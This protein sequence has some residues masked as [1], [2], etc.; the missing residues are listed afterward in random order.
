MIYS[1]G[2]SSEST[3]RHDG[4]IQPGPLGARIFTISA[5]SRGPPAGSINTATSPGSKVT[6][7]HSFLSLMSAMLKVR[8]DVTRSPRFMGP[9]RGACWM[10]SSFLKNRSRSI[11]TTRRLCQQNNRERRVLSS[12]HLIPRGEDLQVTRRLQRPD[13]HVPGPNEAGRKQ[14]ANENSVQH[15][16]NRHHEAHTGAATESIDR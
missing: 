8:P 6:A 9:P 1:C 12:L 10:L 2:G 3:V 11:Q 14:D 13:V 15:D 5:S 16:S 4:W 7:D